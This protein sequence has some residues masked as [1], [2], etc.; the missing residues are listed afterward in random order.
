MLRY[1]RRAWCWWLILDWPTGTI[2][3]AVASAAQQ[4]LPHILMIV[5][6]D[7]GSHD[8]GF[9][10][11]GIRTPHLDAL[12]V[13]N[14]G[15]ILLDQ[16]YVLPYC[17]PTR[18]ALL[19]G[20]YPLHTGCHTIIAY[21]Q[22]QGLPLDEETLPSLLRSVGYRAHAVGKWHL[23]H[24]RWEQTP[25]FRGFES[26]FGYYLGA[27]DYWTHT[28]GDP[29]GIGYDLHWDR[30]EFCGANC[31]VSADERGN[32]ST[33]VFTREAIRIIQQ[34]DQQTNRRRLGS[35][36]NQPQEPLFLYLAHQAVHAPNEVPQRY[37]DLYRNQTIWDQRRQ[38]YAAMLT[39]ADESVRNVTLALQ[40]TNMWNNTLVIVTTDNG[41]PTAVCSIQGSTNRPPRRGG[42]CTIWE[43]GTTGDAFLSG[44]FLE[45]A[46]QQPPSSRPSSVAP[47]DQLHKNANPALPTLPTPPLAPPPP[48]RYPHLFHVVDWFP[49]LAA[50]TGAQRSGT[51]KKPLDG[52]NHWT[53]L[54]LPLDEHLVNPPRQELFVGYSTYGNQWYG[55]ALR[56]QNWKILQGPSGGPEDSERVPPAFDQPAV[57]G[58]T[59]DTYLLFNLLMDPGEEHD[60]AWQHPQIVQRLQKKLRQYQQHYVPPIPT[61]DSDCGPFRGIVN[62]SQFGPTWQPWCTQVVVY[63]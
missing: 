8:L 14:P 31:S 25:T 41:G 36:Q 27:S 49:T 10:G 50:L 52:V 24:S 62:T 39:A 15:S 46:L 47:N 43:G 28:H 57:G 13:S 63:S 56:W 55:P 7:L 19:T 3:V 22:T 58:R 29:G 37:Y 11:S 44:P 21:N 54:T 38:I 9:H 30:R 2:P 32:Y 26:F 48:R 17:S 1:S 4:D 20:R 45:R 53:S 18:A 34:H 33:H 59:N 40:Q 5:L 51:T 16:Y 35:Q 12:A 6:D 61:Y 42:K 23:G 60:V